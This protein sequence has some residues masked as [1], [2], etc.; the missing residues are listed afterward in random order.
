MFAKPEMSSAQKLS[1]WILQTIPVCQYFMD[2][3]GE[4]TVTSPEGDS[5]SKC[6][7][8]LPPDRR[9][10]AAATKRDQPLDV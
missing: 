4:S 2:T 5:S 6:Q 1:M 8:Y 3:L 9:H 10:Q 7:S